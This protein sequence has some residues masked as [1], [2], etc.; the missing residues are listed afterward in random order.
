MP[1]DRGLL[2]ILTRS[3]ATKVSVGTQVQVKRKMPET[4]ASS[5]N[6]NAKRQH[7]EKINSDPLNE[8]DDLEESLNMVDS[9]KIFDEVVAMMEDDKPEEEVAA[10]KNLVYAL[11]I[12]KSK[13]ERMPITIRQFE[14]FQTF[15]WKQRINLTIEENEKIN[16]EYTCHHRTIGR[17]VT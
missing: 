17:K 8:L 13:E 9:Q 7:Q 14:A 3:K 6:P 11:T 5:S 1:A 15:L 2:G 10:K 16:I 4:E 12:H